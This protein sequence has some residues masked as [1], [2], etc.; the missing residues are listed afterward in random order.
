M[1]SITIESIQAAASI[2]TAVVTS[3]ETWRRTAEHSQSD[4]V[5]AYATDEATYL[6]T[7]AARLRSAIAAGASPQ[8]LME[9]ESVLAD[10]QTASAVA[11]N[12]FPAPFPASARLP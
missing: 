7:F 5:V 10:C 2:H 9:L 4:L 1:I 6:E 3:A 11:G 8:Q 12:V